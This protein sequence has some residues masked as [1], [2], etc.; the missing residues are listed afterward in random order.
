GA[1]KR[2]RASVTDRRAGSGPPPS[3]C[4]FTVRGRRGDKKRRS[5]G[6]TSLC[7]PDTTSTTHRLVVPVRLEMKAICRPSRDQR[8]LTL[9]NS[10]YVSGIGYPPNNGSSQSWCH[11]PPKYDAYTSRVPSGETSC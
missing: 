11:F 4:T 5:R 3:S 1:K 7:S 10:P 8:G 9:S 2:R 6:T